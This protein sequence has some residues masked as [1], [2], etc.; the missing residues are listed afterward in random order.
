LSL[1]HW[2]F[3]RIRGAVH[4]LYRPLCLRPFCR[5]S[6]CLPRRVPGA[7]SER[8][9]PWKPSTESNRRFRNRHVR[10]L[11]EFQ[12]LTGCRP[13]EACHL[14]C[15]DIDT[16]SDVWLYKPAHHKTAHH[17][18]SRVIAIGLK[19]QELLRAFFTPDLGAYLFSPIRAVEELTADRSEKRKTLR[20]PSH[21][22]RNATK[23]VGRRKRPPSDHYTRLS[24]LT[25][26]TRGCDRVPTTCSAR[27]T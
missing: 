5:S 11:V 15:P 23:K 6:F 7:A 4:L 13:S 3:L 1:L 12:R 24:Y 17:G 16:G 10:G 14:R 21:M 20:W 25:A 9:I 8:R 19:A 2:D 22:R 27:A 26:V 18:K